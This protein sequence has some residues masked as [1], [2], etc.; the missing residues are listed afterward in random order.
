MKER[1]NRIERVS[2][3]NNS[4]DN[5]KVPQ[6]IEPTPRGQVRDAIDSLQTYISVLEEVTEELV[7]ALGPVLC[8]EDLGAEDDIVN[9][10]TQFEDCDIASNLIDLKR[11]VSDIDRE[12]RCALKRL[13]L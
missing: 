2:K 7:T 9:Q 13:A 6:E 8:P 1:K 12:V 10:G 11:R 5:E 4:K 3:V